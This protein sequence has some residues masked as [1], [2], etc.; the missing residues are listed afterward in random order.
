VTGFYTQHEEF[1]SA[2]YTYFGYGLNKIHEQGRKEGSKEQKEKA[3]KTKEKIK[4]K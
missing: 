4:E 2:S 1:T 3:I